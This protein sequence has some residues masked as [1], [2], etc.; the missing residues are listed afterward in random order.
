M[1]YSTKVVTHFICKRF[2]VEILYKGGGLPSCKR[3]VLQAGR[4]LVAALQK[5]TV[6]SK[7]GFN[8]A[9]IFLEIYGRTFMTALPARL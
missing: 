4:E 1:K 8:S 2:Q 5:E 7:R 9:L 3:V 6:T